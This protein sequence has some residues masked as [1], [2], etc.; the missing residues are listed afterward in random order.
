MKATQLSKLRNR[1][2]ICL[3]DKA[4]K[5][6]VLIQFNKTEK[7]FVC[8][9]RFHSLDKRNWVNQNHYLSLK[10]VDQILKSISEKKETKLSILIV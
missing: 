8:W 4:N 1:Q 10:D 2:S 3:Y 5:I 7:D 9:Q 6:F